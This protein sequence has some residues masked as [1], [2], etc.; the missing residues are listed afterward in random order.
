MPGTPG[1]G[2]PTHR[3]PAD[4]D[5]GVRS[6]DRHAGSRRHPRGEQRLHAKVLPAYGGVVQPMPQEGRADGSTA[7]SA[8]VWPLVHGS[9]FAAIPSS[10]RFE[11]VPTDDWTGAGRETPDAPARHGRRHSRGLHHRA[12]MRNIMPTSSGAIASGYV[13]AEFL[14]T[15]RSRCGCLASLDGR[16]PRRGTRD[17][18]DHPQLR[19]HQDAS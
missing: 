4:D 8:P 10:D 13:V 1:G 2:I 7:T 14:S 19:G 16:S 15:R 12:G 9:R 18:W 6:D 5:D 17:D 11:H 3:S